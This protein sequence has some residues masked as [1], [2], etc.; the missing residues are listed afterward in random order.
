[1][2]IVKGPFQFSGGISGVS[3]YTIAGSDR[4]IMR[5]KGGP[6]ARRIKVGKEFAKLRTHQKE[7][8]ACVKFSFGVRGALGQTY[9]LADYNVSPVWNGMG[10]NLM[11][12]DT[13]HIVGERDLKLS[14][15]KHVLDNFS[16]NRNYAFNAV[17]RVNPTVDVNRD[18]LSV[19]VTFPRFNSGVDILNIQRLPY[20]RL[21]VSIGLVCDILYSTENDVRERYMPVSM[22]N[23]CSKSTISDWQSANDLI[24]EQTLTAQFKD[25]FL[26]D[27]S[28]QIT[29][30]A[31]VGIEF[32]NVGFAGQI[33]EVKRAG[34]AKILA[35]R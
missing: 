30:L 26:P 1:M 4:V 3:F 27:M 2:A 31:S 5:T 8:A 20:F 34:C 19:S 29:V 6:K 22:I 32:G 28:D 14:A 15:Y 10:K 7:W 23:G 16:L 21:I 35:V 11:K 25:D 24:N 12:L 17:L 18:K 33:T 9:R 13:E